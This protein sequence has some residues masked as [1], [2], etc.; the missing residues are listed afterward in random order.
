M[1]CP[2]AARSW[3]HS[4]RSVF[5][6]Q[7]CVTTTASRRR[8]RA[9]CAWY[10]SRDQPG[11]SPHARHRSGTAA[12][13]TRTRPSS[14]KLD[15]PSLRCLSSDILPAPSNGRPTNLS[16][17]R[18]AREVWR[19]KPP[20]ACRT[21][22]SRIDRI[23][24]SRSTWPDASTAIDACAFAPSSRGSS[25]GTSAI[26]AW[27]LAFSPTVVR[28]WTVRAWGAARASTPVPPG[29]SRTEPRRDSL[30]RLNGHERR[31]RT[32]ASGAS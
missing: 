5:A 24:T 12:T 8:E 19:P 22:I 18:S 1:S 20:S 17:K 6:C 11:P 32:A 2:T 16:T 27:R 29:Q 13:S 14:K 21:R 26:A 3:T 15:V 4:A 30:C 9:G 7:A 28:C 25:C 31:V 23:L 10:A